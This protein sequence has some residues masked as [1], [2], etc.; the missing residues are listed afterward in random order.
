MLAIPSGRGSCTGSFVLLE[1]ILND[2]APAAIIVCEA[3]EILTLGALVAQLV[4]ERTMPVLQVTQAQFQ[5][6]GDSGTT[7][8]IGQSGPS[9]RGGSVHLEAIDHAMLA[10]EHGKAAAIAMRLLVRMAELQ[11]ADGLLDVTQV[12]IDGSVY[13]GPGSLRFAQMMLEWGAKLRVPATLNAISVDYRRWRALGVPDSLGVPATALA[14]AYVAMG[15]TP[16]FT[17]APYLLESAPSFG[18][19]IGWGESNAVAYAN[20]VLGARTMKYADMLDLCI[21]ITGRAP[22]AGC[23]LDVGRRATLVLDV[24]Y[25]EDADDSFWPLL[26][27]CCGLHCGHD[28]PLVRGLEASGA[29]VDELKAFAAAF[30]TATAAPMF[31]IEGVTPE[32]AGQTASRTRTIGMAELRA[33]WAELDAAPGDDIGLVSLGNP[34]F[35]VGEFA[36]LAALVRGRTRSPRVP[37]VITCGRDVHRAALE[38]GSIAA[39]EAFGGQIVLDTCWCML[40]EPIVPPSARTLMTNSGKY[41]HYAPGLVGRDVRF[42][43]LATC[44]DAACSGVAGRAFPDWLSR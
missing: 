34:H 20:S 26:G 18:E 9:A 4:F 25:P 16:S 33:A 29:G 32:A 27:Y 5:R 28:I 14:D 39:V 36:S 13:T 37:M 21:A 38:A 43:S 10:G 1:L 40:G 12:H 30:A 15:A 35:S 44:V 23:H 31:H 8:E 41:A 24:E 6:L 11:G 42:A 19:Q 17:C 7:L 22:R 2:M 3:E